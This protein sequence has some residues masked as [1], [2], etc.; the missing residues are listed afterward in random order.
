MAKTASVQNEI[1]HGYRVLRTEGAQQTFDLLSRVRT[2]RAPAPAAP[3][4]LPCLM[5]SAMTV[6][7]DLWDAVP[8]LRR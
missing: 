6:Y 3:D 2:C 7:P 5:V 4:E 8:W 1:I